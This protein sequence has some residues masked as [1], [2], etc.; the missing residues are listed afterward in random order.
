LTKKQVRV[1]ARKR[2]LS[3]WDK[4]DS[5]GICFIGHDLNFREF[6]RRKIKEHEGETVDKTGKVIGRHQGVEFY[7]IGQRYAR[8]LF[9]IEK[10]IKSNRLIVGTKRDLASKEFKVEGWN[11][12]NPVKSL[13]GSTLKCRIRHQGRLIPCKIKGM[14]VI[15]DRPEYGIAPGQIVVIY[16][17]KTVGSV[18]TV[19]GGGVIG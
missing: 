2:G 8:P 12:I 16:Q 1:E 5:S 14:K 17:S 4:K 3:V 18:P 10:D 6:L 19:L 15:L 11:W 13:Q 9:V 7:T